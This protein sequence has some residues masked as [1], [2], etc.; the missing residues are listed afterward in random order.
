MTKKISSDIRKFRWD[1]VQSHIWGRASIY[2]W[3]CA[4]FSPFMR[5]P[6]VIYDFLQS[7]HLNLLIYED[8]CYFIFYQCGG[9]V[10]VNYTRRSMEMDKLLRQ[11]KSMIFFP[12]SCSLLTWHVRV[13][14]CP[15]LPSPS[16]GCWS[17]WSAECRRCSWASLPRSWTMYSSNKIPESSYKNR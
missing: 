3:K 16:T 17:R 6:L 8:N 11:Q 12:Y 9:F 2:M 5:M 14:R 7:I 15:L 4:N 1:R 10:S 13:G